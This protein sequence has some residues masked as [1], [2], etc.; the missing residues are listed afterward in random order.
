MTAQCSVFIATS[1][2]GFISRSDGSIDWLLRLH[3]QMPPGED[4][5]YENFIATIDALVM[6][7]NSF[8]QVLS[9]DKWP[10]GERKVVVMSRSL[11]SLPPGTPPTVS[12]T[13]E[14]PETLVARLSNEGCRRLYIDGG[15]TIQSF[16]KAGLIDDLTVTTIP[17]LIGSGK[18]LFGE[19]NADVML[20]H[21]ATRAY[22]FGFVQSH[23]RVSRH[24]APGA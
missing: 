16:L 1:L 4:A 8:E 17:V 3:N 12:L 23:Y 20:E 7:R 9:F 14:S 10:Y 6:G 2:D 15:L 19:L 21:Q 13:S 24:E 22:E 11:T 5:G 18:P